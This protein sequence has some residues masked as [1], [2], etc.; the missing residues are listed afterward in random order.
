M[1]DHM[2]TE[3]AVCRLRNLQGILQN[4]AAKPFFRKLSS[5]PTDLVRVDLVASLGKLPTAIAP[6]AP[7]VIHD[8]S[9]LQ[10]SGL[11]YSDV[12]LVALFGSP[13][14]RLRQSR[15]LVNSGAIR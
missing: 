9:W 15:Q 4:A 10:T 14:L 5:G 12:G 3:E 13:E 2:R 7:E 6:R 1:F 8:T 11:C